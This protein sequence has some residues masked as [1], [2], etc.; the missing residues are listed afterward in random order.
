ME[1]DSHPH[2]SAH[3][4]T[5]QRNRPRRHQ[6][7]GRRRDPRPDC[8]WL[9]GH[10]GIENTVHWIRDVTFD[11]DRSQIRTGSGPQ[12]M[13]TLR[14]IAISLHRLYGETNIAEACR[15]HSRDAHRPLALLLA[16]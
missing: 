6:S 15:H 12:V 3:R 14:N 5:P 7:L 1:D 8:R 10:W 13:A 16:S 9:R 2:R 4:E 11:E